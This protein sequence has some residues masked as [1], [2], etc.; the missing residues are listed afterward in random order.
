MKKL[1]TMLLILA[2]ALPAAALADVKAWMLDGTWTYTDYMNDGVGIVSLYMT[3]D[4]KAYYT[5]QAFI[6]EEPG[7]SRA[8]VGSWEFTGPDTVLVT[9]G[10]NT[11]IELCYQTFNL[12]YDVKTKS[13]YF[14]AAMRDGDRF[15]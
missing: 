9:I 6:G 12:M 14:R 1:I 8:F 2:L 11:Q 10:E 15:P 5:A 4:G 3:E 13:M 7:I